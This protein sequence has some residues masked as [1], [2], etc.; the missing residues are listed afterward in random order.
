MS[1]AG[2]SPSRRA[3]RRSRAWVKTLATVLV[4]L[5]GFAL[6]ACS[7]GSGGSQSNARYVAGDGSTVIEPIDQ[8]K[9]AP[10]INGETIDGKPFALSTYSGQVVPLNVWA[11]W[12][13][14]C[15]AEAPALEQ[16]ARE[17]DGK[18]VQFV[19]LNTRDT[20]P[21]AL[22]FER[23][24]DISYPSVWD[25]DGKIQLEFRESLPPQAI[26]STLLIDK[27]GMVAGRILGKV[28]RTQLRSIIEELLAEPS[29]GSS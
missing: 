3:I 25:P 16:L 2:P 20:K 18:G 13:A 1:L 17:F 6:S 12:C 28:D 4:I 27:Q 15:R 19:G 11:S 22:A 7:A 29:P 5:C 14:P 26:P 9:L 8:R 10:D 21:A 23:R 24:F